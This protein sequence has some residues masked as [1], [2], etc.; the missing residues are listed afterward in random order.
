MKKKAIN[1]MIEDIW[2]KVLE[3]DQVEDDN[4][5]FDLGGHSLL[6]VEMIYE[7]E[8]AFNIEI[9]QADYILEVTTFKDCV[10]F[11]KKRVKM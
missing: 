8:E 9:N 4:N 5:F 7:L 2:C 10:E 11:I 6:V 3:I 1:E